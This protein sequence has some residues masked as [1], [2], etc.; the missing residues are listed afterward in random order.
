MDQRVTTAASSSAATPSAILFDGVC[1]LCN[2]FT[3][4]IMARDPAP[5]RFR[6][7]ALQS[8]PGQRLLKAH[9]LSTDGLDTIVLIEDGAAFI[10]SAAALRTLRRL[11]LPWSLLYGFIIVP[12]PLRDVVYRF[13]AR[14][15]Y[16]WFGRR[17]A[18]MA[19][20]PDSCGRFLE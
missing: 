11:G 10:R 1:N 20:T 6:F 7:A 12:R 14:R 9:G 17:D 4:F 5:G 8:D 16:R 3:R 15:R 13:V 19:P 2:G 18:C